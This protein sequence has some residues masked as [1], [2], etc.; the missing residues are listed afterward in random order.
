MSDYKQR[1]TE[2]PP[3]CWP[4][5]GSVTNDGRR[6]ERRGSQEV[7]EN[8]WEK[9]YKE[10]K[11]PIRLNSVENGHLRITSDLQTTKRR[12][13]QVF[14]R[15]KPLVHG[16]AQTMTKG[17]TLLMDKRERRKCTLPAYL[18]QAWEN[19]KLD[20][21]EPII[22]HLP[23]T[24]QHVEMKH[25]V[26]SWRHGS[27]IHQGIPRFESVVAAAIYR[28]SIQR[29][30]RITTRFTRGDSEA[31]QH[32]RGVFFSNAEC[33]DTAFRTRSRQSGYIRGD[34]VKFR[35]GR[36]VEASES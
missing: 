34:E 5:D 12:A 8:Q 9:I 15:L 16:Q 32:R 7:E 2:I 14:R 27:I 19:A 35:S 33:L 20:A 36:A 28:W 30:R 18:P 3:S 22:Y 11:D 24:Y 31:A 23:D 10:E 4:D 29:S 21:L 13:C 1:E 6:N 17:S 26:A 25:A